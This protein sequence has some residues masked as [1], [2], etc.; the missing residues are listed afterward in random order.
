VKQRTILIMAAGTG[1]HIFRASPS[2][3]SCESARLERALDGHALGHGE[4][5]RRRG[6]LPDGEHQH[7]RGARQGDRG[8][9]LPAFPDPDRFQQST[10]AIFRIRPTWCSRWAATSPSPAG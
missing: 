7:Q 5:D 4:P 10:L 9:V 2:R 3:L 6:G 1:G 8:V